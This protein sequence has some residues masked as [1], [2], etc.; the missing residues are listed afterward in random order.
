VSRDA[1]VTFTAYVPVGSINKGGALATRK[2]A[3]SVSCG[4]CHGA[5][6][7]GD[8]DIP[9]IVGRSP[10]YTFRQLYDYKHGV[11]AR[12]GSAAMTTILEQLTTTEM[13][14]LPAY[15]GSLAP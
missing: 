13:I 8:G 11:R 15:L 12:P 6:L 4:A 7:K 10:T 14:S 1:Q 2:D 5:S 3:N 9:G